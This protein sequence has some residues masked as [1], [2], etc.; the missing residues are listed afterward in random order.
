[1]VLGGKEVGIQGPKG[2]RGWPRGSK[3]VKAYRV[4]GVRDGSIGSLWVK[5]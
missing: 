4:S 3:G 2:S 1:M 5:G